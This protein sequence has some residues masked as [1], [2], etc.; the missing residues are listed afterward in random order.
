M[1]KKPQAKYFFEVSYEVANKIGGIYTVIKS[2]SPEMVKYYG[3]NYYT[4]G[5]YNP[6]KA[7]IEL[8]P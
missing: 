6:K 3:D 4:I 7:E 5:F 1:T 2:K 8:I